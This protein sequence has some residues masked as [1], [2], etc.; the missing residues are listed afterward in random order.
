M[1]DAAARTVSRLLRASSASEM[2]AILVG[3]PQVSPDS[4][5][6]VCRRPEAH[7]FSA[8][9]CEWL[10]ANADRFSVALRA[11]AGELSPDIPSDVYGRVGMAFRLQGDLE[12]ARRFYKYAF[13]NAS[14]PGEQSAALTSLG[15]L[16]LQAR[17]LEDAEA[18]FER[19][20]ALA[21]RH[22]VGGS[23]L[24]N[25]VNN[26]GLVARQRGNLDQAMALAEEA[27][28]LAYREHEIQA[29]VMAQLNLAAA[30]LEAEQFARGIAALDSVRPILEGS[31][32]PELDSYHTLRR[33]LERGGGASGDVLPGDLATLLARASTDPALLAEVRRRLLAAP[34]S[35]ED[36][37]EAILAADG[38]LAGSAPEGCYPIVR[39]LR[40]VAETR[41]SA[42]ALA[43]ATLHLCR[44]EK[45]STNDSIAWLEEALR[46]YGTV[47]ASSTAVAAAARAQLHDALGGRHFERQAADRA[48]DLRAAIHHWNQALRYLESGRVGD[49]EISELVPDETR[50][51]ALAHLHFK[52]GTAQNALQVAERGDPE[53][54]IRHF[55]AALD[56]LSN[57]PANAE[58]RSELINNLGNALGYKGSTS[59]SRATLGQPDRAALRRSLDLLASNL[60]GFRADSVGR[61]ETL[62]NMVQTY[63]DLCEA[64]TDAGREYLDAA[65][66]CLDAARATLAAM[67]DPTPDLEA[68][69]AD[70]EAHLAID[71][72]AP[73]V[74][75]LRI[76]LTLGRTLRLADRISH[77]ALLA[78]LCSAA[79]RIEERLG[80]RARAYR[81]LLA[82][83]LRLHAGLDGAAGQAAAR[84]SVLTRMNRELT[85]R[86]LAWGEPR[87]ALF[88]V[89]AE[90]SLAWSAGGGVRRFLPRSGNWTL[91]SG[92]VAVHFHVDLEQAVALVATSEGVRGHRYGF[93]PIEL[94]QLGA[95]WLTAAIEA[96][97]LRQ[98][99]AAKAWE[100]AIDGMSE[101]MG[102]WLFA[103]FALALSEH[104][105]LTLV[106]DRSMHVMPL[107]LA[108]IESGAERPRLIERFAVRHC[109]YLDFWDRDGGIAASEGRESIFV[110][111]YSPPEARLPF[112]ALEAAAIVTARQGQ[113]ETVLGED[114]TPE[115]VLE[116]IGTHRAVH[117]CCHGSW[118]W[119]DP[120]EST[121]TLAGRPLTL[122]EIALR[123]EHS[124]CELIVLSACEVGSRA[125]AREGPGGFASVLQRAG[126]LAVLGA[127]WRVDDLATSL[128]VGRFY[129]GWNG[130]A[131]GAAAALCEAQAWLANQTGEDLAAR[132]A[133]LRRQ[134]RWGSDTEAA[135]AEARLNELAAGGCSRPFAHPRY[136]GAFF[137][138]ER[139]RSLVR[140]AGRRRR[141]L[142]ID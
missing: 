107:H 139:T 8:S 100:E 27:G 31:T 47:S 131:S 69:L 78:S 5:M 93:R 49:T 33:D 51:D 68:T 121:L 65:A 97:G 81:R 96:R 135:Y 101:Q 1:T 94:L 34:G 60:D 70:K 15:I 11:I 122:R 84:A 118:A 59:L 13:H 76:S 48:Q 16:E 126:C 105:E 56:N 17:R 35:L 64:G 95:R 110:A 10:K 116:G 44:F 140:A 72:H 14:D 38:P 71:R 36:L 117:L 61:F 41:R 108:R 87:R 58:L 20:R 54:A 109:E 85:R 74:E 40:E 2:V 125:S 138:S 112:A 66:G 119:Q 104:R 90:R 26:L 111:A 86:L 141:N 136:W 115:A 83:L 88:F 114:A 29:F 133:E 79:A 134:A 99:G 128:L 130:S 4:I 63:R 28:R 30:A 21:V 6:A 132:T 92:Q 77:P 18:T 22:R 124:P 67:P 25:I 75:L 12:H 120:L 46:Q 42:G 52:L 53:V 39:L 89:N 73:D 57:Q 62:I 129:E 3:A 55:Q 106:D 82:G 7:G 32:A 9:E 137:V 80:R 142:G 23:T 19:A 91:P 113:A 37:V 98:D 43:S 24:P 127:M 50:R 102:R 103:P 123:L 45:A